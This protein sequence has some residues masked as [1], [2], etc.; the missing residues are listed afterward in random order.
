MKYT[1]G[2]ELETYSSKPE[3]YTMKSIK[4]TYEE[5]VEIVKACLANNLS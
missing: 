4:V 2:D 5:K 1:K 3:L